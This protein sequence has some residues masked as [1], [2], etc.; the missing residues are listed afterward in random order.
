[1]SFMTRDTHASSFFLIVLSLLLLIFF[2]FYI[3]H[4]NLMSHCIMAFVSGNLFLTVHMTG[5]VR[6]LLI[7]YQLTEWVAFKKTKK[8]F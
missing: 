6:T 3:F 4:L 2:T 8:C 5:Q 7:S 1:M